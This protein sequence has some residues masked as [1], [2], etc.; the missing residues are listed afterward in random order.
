M[1]LHVEIDLHDR[2]DTKD[3]DAL[4]TLLG[5]LREPE[6]AAPVPPAPS[7]AKTAKAADDGP[8]PEDPEDEPEDLLGGDGTDAPTQDDAIEIARRLVNEGKSANVKKALTDLKLKKVSDLKKPE[9]IQAFVD[10]LM[11]V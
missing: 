2:I 1:K 10:A 11:A 4:E 5:L 7:P 9:D 3:V 6:P 8:L